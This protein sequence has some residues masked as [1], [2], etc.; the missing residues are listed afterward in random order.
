V[1]ELVSN[2][3]K[4]A[5]PGGASGKIEIISRQTKEGRHTLTVR[6]D[7]VGLPAGLDPKRSTSLGLKL[8]N[9]LVR[10]IEGRLEMENA[11]GAL[12]CITF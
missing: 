1:N 5:F 3:L 4:Y 6:D 12:F 2:S 10:Q 8:V 9:S 11:G 7:G